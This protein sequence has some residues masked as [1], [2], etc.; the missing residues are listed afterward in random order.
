[1]KEI[2]RSILMSPVKK[3]GHIL[4]WSL[5]YKCMPLCNNLNIGHDF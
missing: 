1:M 3:S 2:K 4:F 5:V